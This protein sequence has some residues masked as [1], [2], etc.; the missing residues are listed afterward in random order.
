MQICVPW[1]TPILAVWL[2]TAYC[3][4]EGFAG[5]GYARDCVAEGG[6][7]EGAVAE[8][9]FSGGGDVGDCCP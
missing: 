4:L 3:V 6:V 2:R 8:G 9:G 5:D 1:I 7:A